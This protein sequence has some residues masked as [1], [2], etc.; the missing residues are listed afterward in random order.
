MHLDEKQTAMPLKRKFTYP[1]RYAPAPEIVEAAKETIRRT[2]A[3]ER[4]RNAFGEGKMLGVLAV[5]WD[6]GMELD[7]CTLN[8]IHSFSG[9]T[10]E[11]LQE[12]DPKSDTQKSVKMYGFLAAF[13]GV[14][15]GSSIIEGFVPPVFDLLDPDGFFRAEEARISGISRKIE[16]LAESEGNGSADVQALKIQRKS[17]SDNLQKWIFS[18]YEVRNGKGDKK[19]ILDIFAEHGLIPP[20]GTGECA[21][22]KLLQYAFINGLTPISMGEFWYESPAA[23]EAAELSRDSMDKPHNSRECGRFYPSCS[24]KCGP[25]LRWMLKGIDVDNPYGYDEEHVPEII[26]EDEYMMALAKPAGMLCVPGKDGQIS[27]MERLPQPAY[28]VHRL[29][30]DTS[31]LLLVA[32]TPR[33]QKELQRQFENREI[34]KT[35]IAIVENF[36]G[37]LKTGDHGSIELPMR[38]DVDDRPRQI[39]DRIYGKPAST[40]YEVLGTDE[41]NGTATVRFSPHTGRTHQIRVHASHQSGLCS[42]IAGDLLYGGRYCRRMYLHAESLSFRHPMTGEMMS[43]S[44]PAGF[45]FG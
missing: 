27:L 5:S 45:I 33:V 40:G 26:W 32:K 21:A 24:S 20:G 43:L 42:P 18:M 16:R 22:P 36:S 1:F 6:A 3:S 29:D 35:Y 38:L 28:P 9:Q 17:M 8:N 14:A 25:L 13:S 44:C 10:I 12:A 41:K 31:G 2:E 34:N 30:M 39:V 19:T 15:G 23:A 37:T 11:A 7:E 4:L